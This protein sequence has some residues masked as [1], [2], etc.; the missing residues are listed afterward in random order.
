MQILAALFRMRSCKQP[1]Q[2]A[3]PSS[4]P[5]A[6]CQQQIE[7]ARLFLAYPFYLYSRAPYVA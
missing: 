2:S 4:K 7:S 1:A 6:P 3:A 5:Q